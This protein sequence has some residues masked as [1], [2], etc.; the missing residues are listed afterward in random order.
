MKESI[1]ELSVETKIITTYRAIAINNR[2]TEHSIDKD[3]LELVK[4]IYNNV[5][6]SDDK[7]SLKGIFEVQTTVLI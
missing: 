4:T 1:K 6:A 5:Y 2:G 3:S 7:W